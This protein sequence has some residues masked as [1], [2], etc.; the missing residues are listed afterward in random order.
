MT[1]D[2]KSIDPAGIRVEVVDEHG[3]I[4]GIR[5]AP[6]AAKGVYLLFDYSAAGKR[7]DVDDFIDDRDE[8]ALLLVFSQ[9]PS[10]K[11]HPGGGRGRASVRVFGL[12]AEHFLYARQDLRYG[13][14]IHV[15]PKAC[16][17][18][19]ETTFEA[20]RD[21]YEAHRKGIDDAKACKA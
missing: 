10:R 14:Y 17:P 16:G 7:A 4:S 13:A 5:V 19:S 21:L 15:M 6:D 3:L 12:P 20:S 8:A 1:P 18:R 2:V 11:T 9:D